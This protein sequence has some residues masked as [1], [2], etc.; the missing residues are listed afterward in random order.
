MEKRKYR[1][2]VLLTFRDRA[3]VLDIKNKFNKSN[4]L[5]MTNDAAFRQHN[6]GAIEITSEIPPRHILKTVIL[7]LGLDELDN[8][9]GI[10]SYDDGFQSQPITPSVRAAE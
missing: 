9:D 2:T 6:C 7:T 3:H 4:S 8:V 10:Y 5:N 1:Y